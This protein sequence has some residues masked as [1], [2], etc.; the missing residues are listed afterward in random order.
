M[1]VCSNDI[2]IHLGTRNIHA[3]QQKRGPNQPSEKIMSRIKQGAF[4]IFGKHVIAF[5]F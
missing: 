3:V 4:S 1:D 2:I 5:I